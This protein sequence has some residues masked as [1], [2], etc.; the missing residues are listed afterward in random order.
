[1]SEKTPDEASLNNIYLNEDDT[2]IAFQVE[3]LDIRGRTVQLGET[4]NSILTR[5]QYPEPVSYLLAEALVLTVLLGTSLKLKGKFILQTHSNGPVNMLVCDFSP[6][7]SLRGYARFDEEKLKQARANDQISSETLLGKGTLA[8]TIHQGTHTQHYQG[9]VALD[10]SNL[11]EASH[12]YFDQSEQIPTDIR[13]AVAILT[14]RDQQ[15]K[16]Q[17]SWRAGGILTQLLPQ[18]SSHHKIYEPNKKPKE[19]K[20]R[21]QLE[22]QWQ[23]AKAL[24]ATIEN[25]EL[26]DP[27][28]GSKRLLF[29]LFHE[30]GVKVFN[31]LSLVEQ[32]SCSREKIKEILEGFPTNERKK[33][34]KNKY[35]SVTC[36]FCSTTYRFKLQEF[37]ENKT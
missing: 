10:G 22:N 13:L 23:E 30:Q 3:E 4:L 32:C 12:A 31:P 11:Q 36:E 19:T 35:I 8:F 34:V 28:I 20:T 21:S 16:P 33:M 2:V 17:K 15:G 14:N 26:I 9:I 25:A 7:S 5:H 29:R 1:M 18:A 6:P 27:Q 24:T 37:S